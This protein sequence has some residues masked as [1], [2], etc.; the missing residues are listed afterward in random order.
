MLAKYRPVRR[1]FGV[2]NS[3]Q[4]RRDRKTGQHDTETF[5]K[6][7]FDISSIFGWKYQLSML[8]NKV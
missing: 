8:P 7:F 6:S 5:R 1:P 4:A 2:L 3:D